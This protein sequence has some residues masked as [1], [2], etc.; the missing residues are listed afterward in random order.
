LYG[1]FVWA[2]RALNSQK[3]RFPARAVGEGVINDAVSIVMFKAS[4]TEGSY[5]RQTDSPPL[6]IS[7]VILHTKQAGGREND[8]TAPWLLT[9][10][11]K[12]IDAPGN[13]PGSPGAVKC[14]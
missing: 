12:F 2:R 6:Y 3:R 9:E 14:P 1:G 5:G 11:V 4:L 13:G 10:G 7:F 8:F